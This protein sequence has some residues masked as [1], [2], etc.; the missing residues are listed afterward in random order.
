MHIILN[1]NYLK[2]L[3]DL[4]EKY[5]PLSI[6]H[7]PYIFSFSLYDE[8]IISDPCKLENDC[9]DGEITIG[10]INNFN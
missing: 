2:V 9:E 8:V 7:V 10:K 4:K 3:Y 5:L 1:L 6:N